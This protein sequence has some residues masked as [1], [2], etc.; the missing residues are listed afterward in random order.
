MQWIRIFLGHPLS[1]LTHAYNDDAFFCE[2]LKSSYF[3]ASFHDQDL[4][5][6]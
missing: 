2:I 1:L 4:A 3:S 6:S 5:D